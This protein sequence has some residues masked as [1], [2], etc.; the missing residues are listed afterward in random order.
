MKRMITVGFDQSPFKGGTNTAI[1]AAV[2]F[3]YRKKAAGVVIGPG[4][5][6]MN[7]SLHMRPGVCVEGTP[8]R[9]IFKKNKM[10]S[11]PL[12]WDG[13]QWNDEIRVQD[14]SW[15]RPGIGIAV[16]QSS[17]SD[18]WA[19]N[20]M[21][22]IARK[23]NM[24]KLNGCLTHNFMFQD[25]CFA[26]TVFPPVAF[27]HVD[28]AVLRN[29]IVD[30]NREE[31]PLPLNGCVGSGIYLFFSNGCTIENCTVRNA[32]SDGI[33]WQ[34]SDRITVQGCRVENVAG[35]GLHPGSGSTGS[36][37]MQCIAKGN[38][39]GGMYVCWRVTKSRFR[40]CSF[41]ENCREGVSIGHKDTDNWFAACDISRNGW[42]GLHFR[43]EVAGMGAHRNRFS[44]CTII[45]NGGP[46]IMAEGYTDGVRFERCRI[47]GNT[48]RITRIKQT[49]SLTLENCAY[50]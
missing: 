32:N 19:V 33:S 9:T 17:P 48:Q 46:G 47:T 36:R 45:S 37:V 25:E 40:N 11:S 49:G 14:P 43:P 44:D 21:T 3:A 4:T 29:I 31:N 15:F 41:T 8:G 18:G 2:D 12:L 42:A 23:G 28:G 35:Y 30:G 24:I 27:R 38:G 26:A 22:V 34:R 16:Q 6:I 5:Y 1:Q 13:D 7:D 10:R 50:R 39:A 20:V